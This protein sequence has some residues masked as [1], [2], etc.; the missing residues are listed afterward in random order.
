MPE[1]VNDSTNDQQ[2]QNSTPKTQSQQQ[3]QINKTKK[4][5][6]P[7][8]SRALPD[9]QLPH[10]A[11]HQPVVRSNRKPLHKAKQTPVSFEQQDS[12][13]Q[14]FDVLTINE[15]VGYEALKSLLHK[16]SDQIGEELVSLLLTKAGAAIDYLTGSATLSSQPGWTQNIN[17][18]VEKYTGFKDSVGQ[19]GTAINKYGTALKTAQST[20]QTVNSP[21]LHVVRVFLKYL[22]GR[23]TAYV[24]SLGKD[25]SPQTIHHVTTMSES[26]SYLTDLQERYNDLKQ[27][28]KNRSM[29]LGH[30]IQLAETALSTSQEEL[31]KLQN[32]SL[33]QLMAWGWEKMGTGQS[34]SQFVLTN[35][36]KIGKVGSG[37]ILLAAAGFIAA[38]GSL[39]M[40]K[41]QLASKLAMGSA[42]VGATGLAAKYYDH[43]YMGK[44]EEQEKIGLPK[45]DSSQVPKPKDVP[46]QDRFF[47]MNMHHGDIMSWDTGVPME[48]QQGYLSQ[49]VW[50][51]QE[52]PNYKAGGAE[53]KFGMGFN[54][55]GR[56]LLSSDDHTMRLD[57]GGNFE[58]SNSDIM[59]TDQLMKFNE[60]FEIG[61]V[62]LTNIKVTNKGLH[63]MGLE[64]KKINVAGDTFQ[65]D[66]IKATWSKSKG[67]HF[68]TKA[69]ANLLDH[70]FN[71][72]LSF[73][74]DNDGKLING[75]ISIGSGDSFEI[76]KDVLTISNFLLSG[77][78]NEKN[79]V[80]IGAE[81]DLELMKDNPH[82][83]ANI[84][85]AYVKYDQTREKPWLAGVNVFEANIMGKRVSILFNDAH[86]ADNKLNIAKATL[87]YT[88]GGDSNGDD[89]AL[90]SGGIFGDLENIFSVIETLQVS[91]SVGKVSLSKEGGFKF[92][93]S[94]KWALNKLTAKYAGFTL[95]L[96]ITDEEFEGSLKGDFS[97]HYNIFKVLVETPIPAVPGV[98]LIGKAALDAKLG[99]NADLKVS[100]NKEDQRN[101]NKK[102]DKYFKI[103]GKAGFDAGVG[104]T[105]GLGA[106]IGIAN[107]ASIS[108]MLMGRFGVDMKGSVGADATLVF[109]RHGDKMLRQG[110]LPEDKF[111]MRA[112]AS[113]TPTFDISG[114]LFFNLLQQE[115]SLAQYSL[116]RW[117]LGQGKFAFEAAP[118]ESGRYHI[119]PDKDNTTLNGKKFL[120]DEQEGFSKAVKGIPAEREKYVKMRETFDQAEDALGKKSKNYEDLVEQLTQQGKGAEQ[121]MLDTLSIM[122]AKHEALVNVGG[123]Q[124]LSEASRLKKEIQQLKR[125][126]K[127]VLMVNHDPRAAVEYLHYYRTQKSVKAG[128]NKM[129]RK[130]FAIWDW[131]LL[132]RY[133]KNSLAE[134]GVERVYNPGLFG[135]KKDKQA[136]S[137][138]NAKLRQREQE[139]SQEFDVDTRL[140]QHVN[141]KEQE[142]IDLEQIDVQLVKE[143]QSHIKDI[144]SDMPRKKR[145]PGDD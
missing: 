110:E 36:S 29:I 61:A 77:S 17:S 115:F 3:T 18:Y 120:K 42:A 80:S 103:S 48:N 95:D 104:L 44:Q 32:F 56:K 75:D 83:N 30:A 84:S 37:G 118:D 111:K 145:T 54:I 114:G 117:E 108:G 143:V 107:V 2:Q 121:Q 105:A 20:Y 72:A 57:W 60:A 136:H 41:P 100:M 102:G 133:A 97:Q 50:G 1:K 82:F 67:I 38:A 131:R 10:K 88:K 28:V 21:G 86:I 49:M 45:V 9:S 98:N 16:Y 101:N 25:A 58:Y 64:L 124:E 87:S 112:E 99:A 141:P 79:Q 23:G 69:Q 76:L 39:Y 140:A 128:F 19:M 6:S 34:F 89:G 62:H 11:K 127:K 142:D 78:I 70:Q 109:N 52:A 73:D 55:F 31:A 43:N 137:A 65:V 81:S 12:N 71:G 138:Y 7:K 33:S 27:G 134:D 59:I 132:N 51:K 116:A 113:V 5:G 63:S 53:V 66:S 122:V 90:K 129:L 85:K 26:L 47:W 8:L 22:L 24:M 93:E 96:T 119:T 4:G 92:G 14:V 94:P 125:D 144:E 135:S 13:S 123:K 74:L 126:T 35:N 46:N 68:E 139:I 91:A 106:S 15:S 130:H 40:G